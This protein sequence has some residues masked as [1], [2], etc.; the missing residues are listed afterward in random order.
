MKE[1][2]NITYIRQRLEPSSELK[3]SVMERASKLEAGRKT[4]G[5]ERTK[6]DNRQTKKEQITMNANGTKQTAFVKKRFPAAAIS[7]AACAALI[8]GIAAANTNRSKVERLDDST[9]QSSA[10]EQTAVTDSTSSAETS[11]ASNSGEG[12]VYTADKL[13]VRYDSGLSMTGSEDYIPAIDEMVKKVRQ[14]PVLNGAVLPAERTIV[15]YSEGE[16]QTVELCDAQHPV[17]GS[18]YSAGTDSDLFLIVRVNGTQYGVDFDDPAL[19]LD[20]KGCTEYSSKMIIERKDGGR[21]TAVYD[22]SA[23]KRASGLAD[24]IRKN[25]TLSDEK[26]LPSSEC[27]LSLSFCEETKSITL[28]AWKDAGLIRLEMYGICGN[29]PRTAIYSGAGSWIDELYELA[30]T[31]SED[32]YPAD[33]IESYYY[34]NNEVVGYI[35]IPGLTN[36][37]GVKYVNSPVTQHSDNEY[38]LSHDWTGDLSEAGCIFADSAAQFTRDSR[39]FNICLYG[40]SRRDLGSMF[41]HLIDLN[42]ASGDKLN[43]CSVIKFGTVWDEGVSQYAVIGAGIIDADSAAR[44]ERNTYTFDGWLSGIKDSCR[45][46]RDLDCT[47][48][49]EYLTLS[50]N[51]DDENAD[52]Q[53]FVVFARK[54]RKGETYPVSRFSAVKDSPIETGPVED[55][56]LPFISGMTEEQ[57]AA[58]LDGAGLRCRTE[59]VFSNN[60]KGTVTDFFAPY[61]LPDVVNSPED[62]LVSKGAEISVMVSGGTED[63]SLYTDNSG[64]EGELMALR[65]PLPEG[66]SGEYGFSAFVSGS[67]FTSSDSVREISGRKEFVLPVKGSGKQTVSVSAWYHRKNDAAPVKSFDYASFEVDF[68]AHTFTLAGEL[69]TD[70]LI[71]AM[72]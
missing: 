51:I 46:I 28:R 41:T 30:G 24:D 13:S 59:Y 26:A 10:A 4:F 57:A 58:A 63:L 36:A 50:T 3:R 32:T 37:D 66:I 22:E 42:D 16:W 7:A 70:E 54:L 27:D 49:D 68:D 45:L 11:T 2:E 20:L 65:I 60:E 67:R 12:A 39:P 44:F 69:N 56:R 25:G 53:R 61:Y 43:E 33:W 18:D 19:L 52:G 17:R 29:E 35:T 6:A 34:G 62:M 5:D 38:Y 14:C 31:L 55:V 64:A 1:K 23:E 72:N 71:N 47:A 48:E 40:K 9:G 8:I 15:Y 21:F